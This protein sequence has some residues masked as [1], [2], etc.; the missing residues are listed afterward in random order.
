MRWIA[1]V[2]SFGHLVGWSN[3]CWMK[4]ENVQKCWMI[5]HRSAIVLRCCWMLLDRLAKEREIVGIGHA[6]KAWYRVCVDFFPPRGVCKHEVSTKSV[7]WIHNRFA[8]GGKGYTYRS[9]QGG[10]RSKIDEIERTYFM[11]GLLPCLW[12]MLF[13]RY[14]KRKIFSFNKCWIIWPPDENYHPTFAKW[15]LDEMLD[16]LATWWNYHPTFAKWMLDEMLDRLAGP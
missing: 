16:R 15:M 7:N 4:F 8:N 11:N 13:P 1:N 12:S 14:L 6:H 10:R 5:H 3:K 2:G 9:I